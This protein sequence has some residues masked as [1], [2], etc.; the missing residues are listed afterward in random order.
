MPRF[1]LAAA[2]FMRWSQAD[3]GDDLSA[4]DSGGLGLKGSSSGFQPNPILEEGQRQ[5]VS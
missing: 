4:S 2:A 1:G 5:G 3:Q